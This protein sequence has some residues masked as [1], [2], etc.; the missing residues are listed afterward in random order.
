MFYF[1]LNICIVLTI[2][3]SDLTKNPNTVSIH[4]SPEP[5]MVLAVLKYFPSNLSKAKL[6]HTFQEVRQ[7]LGRVLK[8]LPQR[9]DSSEF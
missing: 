6:S 9:I 4:L 3:T 8:Y 2:S 7:L 5:P 1:S